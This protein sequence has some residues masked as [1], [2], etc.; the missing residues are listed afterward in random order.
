MP[1]K[2]YR[3]LYY[4][5]FYNY[6][7]VI[8]CIVLALMIYFMSII[9]SKILETNLNYMKMIED[10]TIQYLE[11][12][13]K[14]VDNINNELYQSEL[15]LDD[16]L[17]YIEYEDEE[18][19]IYRLNTYIGSNISTY[20][21]FEEFI[22]KTLQ[23]YSNILHID[24]FAYNKLKITSYYPNGKS[25]RTDYQDRQIEDIKID[26]L[27]SYGK[28]AF[29]KEIRNP[30]TFQNV[31]CMIV[32]FKTDKLEDI[33]RYYS[34]AE[35]I[36][37]NNLGTII[38]NSS[39]NY[40]IEDL[41]IADEK[42]TIEQFLSA[43]VDKAIVK[44]YIVYTFL[45][46]DKASYIPTSLFITVLIIG[47]II[48]LI[49]ELFVNHYLENLAN[50]LDY[51]LDG[52]QKVTTGD[53]SIKLDI[54]KNGDELDLISE[55]FNEM[56][57]KLDHYIQK[58]Y[59]AEIE[60]KNAEIEVLQNQI[61]PHFLYNT[62][63]A[64]RMKAICNGD[65]EVGKMLYSMAVIFRSQLKEADFITL[66]QEIHYCKK[67]LELFEYRYQGKFTSKV[68]CPEEL[69][70]YQVIKFILQPII[71]NYFIHGI[72]AE[73]QGNEIKISAEEKE[74]ALLIHVIDNGQGMDDDMMEKKN[75]ELKLNKVDTKKSIGLMNVNKRIK[76]IY[77]SEFGV[78]LK[79]SETNGIHVIVKIGLGGK[80]DNEKSYVN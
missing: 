65:R 77:G 41:I 47:F 64:I 21:G 53:L 1:K 71:E 25:Y 73:I 3:Q 28:F 33:Q 48:I 27:D 35:I 45:R 51:I 80:N 46:K 55:N 11:D 78:T 26:N 38:F 42:G 32:T 75:K 5:L 2:G 9:R 37:F 16:L 8:V 76:A 54:N 23:N 10:E 69:M 49:G 43:Y 70:N 19:Q 4:K 20:S 79:H 57:E 68:E 50:R 40:S 14:I 56:C 17:H 30:L 62:L 66:I 36:V 59:L 6:T 58:S 18:Y 67:Y 22:E 13:S 15:A 31:G 24:F 29:L 34:N 7:I 52:M 39:K 12:S 72:R 60:Q 44:D 61:N 74:N 63:E